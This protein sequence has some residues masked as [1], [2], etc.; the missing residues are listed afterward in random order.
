M[1]ADGANWI[2]EEARLNLVGSHGVLDIYHA[3]KH[4]SDTLKKL[5]GDGTAAANL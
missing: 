4:V 5:F 1:L 3:L 2:W